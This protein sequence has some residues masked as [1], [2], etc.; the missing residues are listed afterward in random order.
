MKSQRFTYYSNFILL[1]LIPLLFLALIFGLIALKGEGVM[2]WIT[3]GLT[4]WFVLLFLHRR[5]FVSV[6]FAEDYILYKSLFKEIKMG[7][8]D[9]RDLSY[10]SVGSSVNFTPYSMSSEAPFFSNF[11][12]I[13]NIREYP[14]YKYF[15]LTK[16]VSTDIGQKYITIK[17][18]RSMDNALQNLY[19]VLE[20]NAEKD[21]VKK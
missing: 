19:K 15:T 18:R 13:G 6:T 21:S 11:I 4:I 1:P 8:E 10:F 2:M 20:Q 7:H 9:L 17:Y 5:F 14:N 3:F 16:P 12:L